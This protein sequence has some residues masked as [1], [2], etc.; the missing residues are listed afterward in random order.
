MSQKD[1]PASAI[2]AWKFQ[3]RY[4]PS[5]DFEPECSPSKL[6][7]QWA[8]HFSVLLSFNIFLVSKHFASGCLPLSPPHS[9]SFWPLV[10]SLS[11]TRLSVLLSSHS[12]TTHCPLYFTLTLTHFT[13]PLLHPLYPSLPHGLLLPFS[14]FPFLNPHLPLSLK[15]SCFT[16]CPLFVQHTTHDMHFLP[17][18]ESL[19]FSCL[20]LRVVSGQMFFPAVGHKTPHLCLQGSQ[21]WSREQKYCQSY[22][23][24]INLESWQG[25]VIIISLTGQIHVSFS[26]FSTNSRE[27]TVSSI[28]LY[29]VGKGVL[30]SLW[31][32]AVVCLFFFSHCN[33]EQKEVG[34]YSNPLPMP[35]HHPLCSVC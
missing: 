8:F 30:M 14:S 21:V 32:S 20:Y 5:F 19:R 11:D 16:T 33:A 29:H 24:Q 2:S 34:S 22:I 9:S 18:V 12:F 15:L 27:V 6:S 3:E 1:S 10:S 25:L 28:L 23:I 4:I 35:S 13:S 7:S 17:G 31:T 26:L